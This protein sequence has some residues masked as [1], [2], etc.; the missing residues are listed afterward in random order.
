MNIS[1]LK[2]QEQ[3]KISVL[4]N[5]IGLFWAFSDK[6]FHE[7]KTPLR[8]GEKYIRIDGGG[9]MPAGNWEAFKKG[10]KEIREWYDAAIK[11][12][13][14]RRSHIVYELGNHEA[15]YTCDIE[16]TLAALG[17]DYTAE[18]V[19][20]VFNEEREKQIA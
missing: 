2:K 20:L 14:L 18:E 9:F 8:E 19:W 3:D 11:G 1:E 6:Q 15:W 7:N 12:D 10:M 16:S 4:F 17:P 5:E 13:N